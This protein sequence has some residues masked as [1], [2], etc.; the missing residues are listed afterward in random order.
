MERILKHIR[1]EY[2]EKD[3]EYIDELCD[4]IDSETQ[5]I[6]DYLGLTEFGEPINVK[7]LATLEELRENYKNITHME[8]PEWLSGNTYE[9]TTLELTLEEYRKTQYHEDATVESLEALILHEFVHAVVFR[10]LGRNIKVQ[11]LSDGLACYL[12]KQYN[13]H[14]IR[15]SL[16][17]ILNEN[18][19]YSIYE[20]MVQYLD[21]TK[22]RDYILE[23]IKK[24]KEEILEITPEVYEGA[25]K[26]YP[27]IKK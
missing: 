5:G 16:E 9:D 19:R 8:A 3:L 23:L 25:K 13:N 18:A 11:W 14:T 2:T 6:L 7:L 26:M 12:S 15:D 27:P 20:T 1:I 17:D 21:V 22:G 4:Y 24:T 10:I